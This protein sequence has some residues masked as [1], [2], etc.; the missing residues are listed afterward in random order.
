MTVIIVAVSGMED[1]VGININKFIISESDKHVVYW[2]CVANSGD[3]LLK[4]VRVIDKFSNGMEYLDSEI[5]SSY[6]QARLK[7]LRENVS[8]K[9]GDYIWGLGDFQKKENRWIRLIAKKTMEA[10]KSSDNIAYAIGNAPSNGLIHAQTRARYPLDSMLDTSS[11]FTTPI[12]NNKADYII[13]VGNKGTETLSKVILE[14]NL[15]KNLQFINA[16]PAPVRTPDP[17]SKSQTLLWTLGSLSPGM[18]HGIILTANISSNNAVAYDLRN[19]KV[20][21]AAFA[22]DKL[23]VDGYKSSAEN[24]ANINFKS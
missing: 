1:N 18:E 14:V 11:I 10:S 15:E 22:D 5:L 13:T 9:E 2:I 12:L 19:T 24:N 20:L 17:E 21:A 4:N 7:S 8:P 23:I 3:T 16:V 6:D